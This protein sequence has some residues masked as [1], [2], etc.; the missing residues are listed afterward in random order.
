MNGM[1]EERD[2]IFRKRSLQFGDGESGGGG[3]EL[4]SA[5]YDCDYDPPSAANSMVKV[6]FVIK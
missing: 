5:L 2:Y 4:S 6:L 1:R 3:E